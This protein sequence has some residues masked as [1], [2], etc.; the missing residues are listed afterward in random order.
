MLDRD[1]IG[2][3]AGLGHFTLIDFVQGSDAPPLA[4]GAAEH[5]QLGLRGWHG[6]G[7]HRVT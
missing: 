6:H 2:A 3:Y 5:F 4:L 7:R 1:L